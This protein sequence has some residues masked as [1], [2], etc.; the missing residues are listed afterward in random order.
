MQM[1]SASLKRGP[2]TNDQNI[3]GVGED[4]VVV[5]VPAC[6]IDIGGGPVAFVRQRI[7]QSD[8][9][10]QPCPEGWRAIAERKIGVLSDP[11]GTV[12]AAAKS[13]L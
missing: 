11:A 13:A 4:R 5:C 7:L 1:V 9:H 8:A 3:M 2:A 10:V 12:R 6:A